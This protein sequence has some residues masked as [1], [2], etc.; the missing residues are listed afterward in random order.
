M[1]TASRSFTPPRKESDGC[2]V[3]LLDLAAL[4]EEGE[5][6]S[7]YTSS[8]SAALFG[9]FRQME[10]LVEEHAEEARAA[11]LLEERCTSVPGF[12]CWGSLLSWAN[13]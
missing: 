6:V 7:C 10:E 13:T 3:W 11:G 9:R 8:V 5:R 2:L 4:L 1:K 12:R